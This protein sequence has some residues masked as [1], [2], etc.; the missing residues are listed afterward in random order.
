MAAKAAASHT[1]ALA[2]SDDV[3][4][5][6]RT[7]YMMRRYAVAYGE[8]GRPK[9]PAVTPIPMVSPFARR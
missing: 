4:D 8:I 2:G 1:G 9:P 5:A 7:A 3:L 6:V